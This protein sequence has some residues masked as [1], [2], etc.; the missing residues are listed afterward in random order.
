MQ[1]FQP[2]TIS[3][4]RRAKVVKANRAESPD[5][6]ATPARSLI[7]SFPRFALATSAM[8]LI[9]A[10]ELFL[11]SAGAKWA[12]IL[13]RGAGMFGEDGLVLFPFFAVPLVLSM[14]YGA[15]SAAFAGFFSAV[16]V[17][18]A[19]G[20]NP[21]AFIS[22]A[23]GTL[24]A[25]LAGPKVRRVADFALSAIRVFS[26][27]AVL[28]VLAVLIPRLCG[29]TDGNFDVIQQFAALFIFEMLA[30]PASIWVFLPIA[31][32]LSGRTSSYTLSGFANLENPLLQRLSREAPGTYGHSM[33]VA[34]L[35]SAA[36]ETVGADSLL[37]RIGGYFHDI[38]KLSNPRYF[39]ENQTALGNPHDALPPS[40]SVM[41]IASHIKDGVILAREAGLPR[42]IARII[43][44]HHGRSEM[45]WF[46]LK[47]E[48][49][50]GGG[51]VA[52]ESLFRYNGM[53]PET[54]EETIVSL[55]DSVEAASR[56]LASPD[57][58]AVTRLVNAIFAER[59]S[60]GQLAASEMKVRELEAVKQTMILTIVH[61]LHVRQAYPGQR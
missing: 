11:Y 54:K 14:L 25:S 38:G 40:I 35:A 36:A 60:D 44:S 6:G 5:A 61:R 7:G 45:K 55:A 21:C 34:D 15:R 53:L 10:A 48:E 1:K 52:D 8:L 26:T 39:M 24:I 32:R 30:V 51:K 31:E 57:G 46:R 47:A 4:K 37:A 9:S 16:V 19:T 58:A 13:D 41:I 50:G 20:F 2:Q 56:A 27:Q 3:S 22:A 28:C 59:I 43:E 23:T 18:C 17:W 29:E 42:S 33:N 12:E 49:K